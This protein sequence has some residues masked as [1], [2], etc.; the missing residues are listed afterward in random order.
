MLTFQWQ[1]HWAVMRKQNILVCVVFVYVCVCITCVS[2]LNKN[3]QKF[4]ADMQTYEIN[5]G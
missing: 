1:Q 2:K 4:E 3:D 5:M